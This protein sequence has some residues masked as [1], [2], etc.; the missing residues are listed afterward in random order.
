MGMDFGNPHKDWPPD[1]PP[2]GLATAG[3][4]AARFAAL[5]DRV[6][7]RGEVLVWGN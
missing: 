3:P 6:Q 1:A 5:S 7:A 4:D 2:P